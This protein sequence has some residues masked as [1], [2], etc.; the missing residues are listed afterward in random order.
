MNVGSLVRVGVLGE[1]Y[2]AVIAA[3]EHVRIKLWWLDGGG[4]GSS[5]DWFTVES[6]KELQRN[7]YAEMIDESLF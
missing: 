4:S 3:K 6:L 5:Y 7:G 1:W 2:I